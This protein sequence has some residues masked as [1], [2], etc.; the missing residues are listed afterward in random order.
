M[1]NVG[2][3]QRVAVDLHDSLLAHP[4]VEASALVLRSA[5]SE[6]GYRTPLFLARALRE[7]RRLARAGEIDAILFSSMVTAVVVV[8]LRNLLRRNGIVT[9]AIV[10][11][12][13]ATTPTWPYPA[14]VRS[15][16]D[17]LDIVLPIS[18][19]TAAA[20]RVRGLA[21]S[22][23]IVAPLGVRAERF[24]ASVDRSVAR[25]RLLL[26]TGQAA[27]LILCSV[28]RLVPRK[29]VAWF[30]ENV[31]PM[32]PAD[33][34]YLIAGEGPDRARV[35]RAIAANGLGDRVQ[36]L[37][38][39]SDPELENLYRGSDLFMMPN[40][41]V[42]NDMEGFG[43]VMLEAGLCGLPTIAARVDGI[44]DVVTEGENGYLVE[45]GD[46]ADFVA[47]VRRFYDDPSL[48]SEVSERTR[49]H[50]VSTFG[51]D[52][53]IERYISILSSGTA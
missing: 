2:G 27:R 28:G 14:L 16:F 49:Q 48:L 18:S 25:E 26:R 40:V 4:G 52:R 30:V 53:V 45:S 17:A 32:L 20:C 22:R 12:L 19:A 33:V 39:I 13:D 34:H 3:M 35:E 37:G 15:T 23:C 44:S 5:W 47:A 9:A 42:V 21:E 36:L 1:E 31:M 10:N 43:L 38:A 29:G 41:R 50:T 51:W 8:P 11:G 24:A 46:A 6:R 7:I